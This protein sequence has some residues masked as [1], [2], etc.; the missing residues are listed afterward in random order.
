MCFF[1]IFSL[2]ATYTVNKDVYNKDYETFRKFWAKIR[3]VP[4]LRRNV[5]RPRHGVKKNITA[6][7]VVSVEC[8]DRRL[9][10]SSISI[11]YVPPS[12][13]YWLSACTRTGRNKHLRYFYFHQFWR[14]CVLFSPTFVCLSCL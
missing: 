10:M 11:V 8:I 5:E 2:Y 9:C 12:E 3:S 4:S 6:S 1:S 14:V 7:I 13:K